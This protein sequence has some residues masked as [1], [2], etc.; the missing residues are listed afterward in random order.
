MRLI[1]LAVIVASLAACG[2]HLSVVVPP[3]ENICATLR[4]DPGITARL[5]FG[6]TTKSGGTVDNAA[7]QKFL[8]ENV[9]PRFPSGFSVFDGYGQ[10]RQRGTGRIIQEKS[11]VIEIATGRDAD[12]IWKFE[13]IRA[14]YRGKFNQE[15]AGLVI[16]DSCMSF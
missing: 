1:P 11:T 16:S 10:W 15:S 13:E 6:R 2:P 4:G 8:A 7:W 14:E 9:T 3:A 12:A 5:Y